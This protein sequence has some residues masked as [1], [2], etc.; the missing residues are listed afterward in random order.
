MYIFNLSVFGIHIAPTWY[1]LMYALGFIICYQY[2][3]KSGFIKTKDMDALLFYIFLGVIVWWRLGYVLF[4]N[5]I[6]FIQNPLSIPMTWQW[7][8]SFHGWALGVILSMY[9][10]SRKYKYKLFDVSD[11]IVTI[12][13]VALWLGRIWNYINGELLWFSPYTWTFSITKWGLQYFPSTLLEAFLEWFILL[14]VLLIWR[15]KTKG[16]NYIPWSASAIFL[17]WYW[18]CRIFSEFFRLPDP[19][20]WYLFW[21]E[22]ITL[23]MVYTIPMIIGWSILLYWTQKN[24][25][26]KRNEEV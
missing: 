21:T 1:G 6:F 12:L 16:N 18:I 13:P 17:I 26:N 5:P 4:Y 2:V 22:L 14:C 24:E 7:G 25:K 8:M 20:I 9:L 3:K 15:K 11:P 19:G 10:F 23:G